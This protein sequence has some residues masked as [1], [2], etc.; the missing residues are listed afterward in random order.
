MNSPAYSVEL[1][2]FNG[3]WPLEGKPFGLVAD[4]SKENPQNGILFLVDRLWVMYSKNAQVVHLDQDAINTAVS[5]AAATSC[6][7]AINE[8]TDFIRSLGSEVEAVV[9]IDDLFRFPSRPGG[10]GG[11]V[12]PGRTLSIPLPKPA[13][14][15]F[16]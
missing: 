9:D 10:Q 6:A 7:N 12:A 8:T 1:C 11:P 3:H 15:S 2:P 14:P 13:R 5:A 4:L 16:A